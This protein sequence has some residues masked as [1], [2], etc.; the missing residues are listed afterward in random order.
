V[1]EGLRPLSESVCPKTTIDS[2]SCHHEPPSCGGEGSAFSR[3]RRDKN[4]PL[5]ETHPTDIRRTIRRTDVF[6]P[7][8]RFLVRRISAYFSMT[9]FQPP[10]PVGS[11]ASYVKSHHRA[12]SRTRRPISSDIFTELSSRTL[13]DLKRSPI[14]RAP[15]DAVGVQHCQFGGA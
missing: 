7:S 3:T 6:Y 8:D 1:E 14:E 4:P 5:S 9:P 10:P 15:V 11:E 2:P 13:I 12:E